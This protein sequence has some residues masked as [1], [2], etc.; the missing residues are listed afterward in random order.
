MGL[1]A[2][3]GLSACASTPKTD[4]DPSADFSQYRTFQWQYSENSTARE[5]AD[6]V[7]DSP[8]FEKKLEAAVANLMLDRGFEGSDTPDM[9]LTY[10]MA[11]AKRKNY[12]VNFAIGYG[13]YSRHSYW[14]IYAPRLRDLQRD[15]VLVIVDAL[16]AN[17]QELVWRG[18]TKTQRRSR[19][20]SQSDMDRLAGK[21]LAG[22]PPQ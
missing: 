5:L 4:F 9:Y 15:E 11:D 3:I 20:H 10:H 21:I 13:R 22:F 18:W 7:Y 1:V 19:P 2:I 12:P 8:L 6:P 16:D 14:N 17:T